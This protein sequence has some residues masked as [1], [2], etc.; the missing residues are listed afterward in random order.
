MIFQHNV[1][2]QRSDARSSARR[3]LPRRCRRRALLDEHYLENEVRLAA[4]RAT[5]SSRGSR[6]SRAKLRDPVRHDQDAYQPL[7]AQPRSGPPGRTTARRSSFFPY[8]AMGRVRLDHLE[9]ASTPCARRTV[10]RRPRRVRHRARR[11]RDLHARRTSTPT[12]CRDRRVWVADRFRVVTGAAT[13]AE[14][15]DGR[16]GRLPGRPQ[17]RARRLRPLRPA[18]RPGALPPGRRS[19]RHAA[20]RADRADRA[21][22][23]RPRRS[24]PTSRAVLEQLYDRRRAR[25]RSSSS[26]TTTAPDVPQRGR[27]VPRRRAASTHRSSAIDGAAVVWRKTDRRRAAPRARRPT[28]PAAARAAA[29][30]ARARPTSIDLS[31]VVVFYNMRREAART[32]HSLSRAYQQG[33]DDLDYEVIV[34]ENGS[35]PDE[36]ARRGVRAELR[37]GVPLPRPR[38]RR[39]AVARRRAQPRASQLGARRRRSR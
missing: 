25:R 36:Q 24:A 7:A 23:H 20:R 2:Y 13:G 4:P 19:T 3:A 22:A 28:R 37:P 17:P 33:I 9:R 35:D 6:P 8:T 14:L 1:Y 5:A 18:R 38:R 30:A 29:R 31:V 16:R 15:A 32:L 12:S 26:T 11:R 21:A 10:R 34:V 39:D 27:R